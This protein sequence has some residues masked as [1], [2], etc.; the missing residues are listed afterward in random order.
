MKWKQSYWAKNTV[1]TNKKSEC[2]PLPK[3]DMQYTFQN[4]KTF[5]NNNVAGTKTSTCN[6]L[7]ENRNLNSFVI[8]LFCLERSEI[9]PLGFVE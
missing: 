3:G 6:S 2:S 5:Q 8:I 1:T 4:S 9:T 7:Q